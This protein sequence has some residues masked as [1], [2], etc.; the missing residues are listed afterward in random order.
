M[1]NRTV[2]LESIPLQTSIKYISDRDNSRQPR[3]RLASQDEAVAHLLRC[4]N[5]G[6]RSKYRIVSRPD[7]EDRTTKRPDY[8]CRRDDLK[9]KSI[10][11]EVSRIMHHHDAIKF[12]KHKK[13]FWVEVA[14]IVNWNIR[15]TYSLILPIRLDTPGKFAGLVSD[16]AESIISESR[17]MTAHQSVAVAPGISI[18]KLWDSGSQVVSYITMDLDDEE[19]PNPVILMSFGQIMSAI[20]TVLQEA[21]QKLT[22]YSSDVRVV[23]LDCPFYIDSVDIEMELTAIYKQSYPSIDRVYLLSRA[24]HIAIYR[25]C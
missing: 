13:R 23:L 19:D 17:H 18:F 25:L 24:D 16:V 9:G 22:S 3:L 11:V 2:S 4:L 7:E 5:R 8:V 21:N 15:G 12:D 1:T 20:E 14:K 6:R 10:V